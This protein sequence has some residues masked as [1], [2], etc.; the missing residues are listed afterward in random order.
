MEPFDLDEVISSIQEIVKGPVGFDV[1]AGGRRGMT[2]I[3]NRRSRVTRV[4][5]TQGPVG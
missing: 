3:M 5:N 4:P 1:F 2:E